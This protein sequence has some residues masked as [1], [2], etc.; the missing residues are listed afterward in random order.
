MTAVD[1]TQAIF[2]GPFTPITTTFTGN[3]FSHA[4]ISGSNLTAL[5]TNQVGQTVLADEKWGAGLVMFGGM[6]T[7][8]FHS[9]Q[10]QAN[11]LLDNIIDYTALAA[12]GGPNNYSVLAN[13]G[14]TLTIN[15]QTPLGPINQ[16]DPRI[17][18]YD[19]TG[20]LVAQDDNSAA[21]GRNSS[22]V[23]TA[24]MSGPYTVRVIADDT[25]G[26]YVL[27]VTGYTGQEAPFTATAVT[28]SDDALLGVYPSTYTIHLS[29]PVLL[30]TVAASDLTIDGVA[31]AGVTVVDPQTLTFDLTGTN[32]GNALYHAAIGAGVLTSWSGQPLQAFAATFDADLTPPQVVSSSLAEGDEVHT[33]SLVYTVTF[34]KQMATTGLGVAAAPLTNDVTNQTILP[35]SLTFDPTNTVATITYSNLAES[36]YTLTL[37][38]SATAFRDRRGLLLTGGNYLVDFAVDDLTAPFPTPLQPVAPVG[39]EVF[40]GAATGRFHAAGNVDSYTLNLDPGQALTI[41]LAGSDPSLSGQIEVL[42]PDG[43]IVGTASAAAGQTVFLQSAQVATAGTYTIQVSSLA[44]SGGYTVAATLNASVEAE[45]FGGPSDDTPATAQLIDG[46]AISLQGGADRLAVVGSLASATDTDEYAFTLASGQSASVVLRSQTTGVT[47]QL[48]LLDANGNVLAL[49]TTDAL[50]NQ[51]IDDFVGA[52][53]SYLIRITGAAAANYTVVVTRGADYALEPS[54]APAGPQLISLNNQVLGALSS[55]GGDTNQYLVQGGAGQALVLT[56]TTPGSGPGEPVNQVQPHLDL[57]DPSGHLVASNTG[58]AADGYN[59]LLSYTIPVGDA[60]VYKVV[61]TDVSTA[62]GPADTAQNFDGGGTPYTLANNGGTASSILSGGPTGNFLRLTPAQYY[63][64]N[65]IAF[66]RTHVG[67]APTTVVDFDFRMTPSSGQADGLG[68]AWLNTA[69]YGTTGSANVPGFGE[70]PSLPGSLGVGFDIYNNGSIDGNSNNEVSLHFNNQILGNFFPAFDLANGQFDHAEIRITAG[71]GG[72]YV[73]VT[74]TPNGGPAATLIDNYFVAGM[75]PYEGRAAFS[76][77]TG[78]QTADEDLDNITVRDTAGGAYTLN[79]AGALP[80]NTPAPSV[81]ATT[82]YDGQPT[83][84]PP[85]TLTVTLSSAIR[86]DLL[87]PADLT[88]G[89]GVTVTGVTM[90][91]GHTV[92]FG[93]SVPNV[94]ATYAY[95]FAAGAFTDLQGQPSAAY[96]SSFVI[97]QTGPVVVAQTPALQASVPFNQLGITFNENIDPTT[98]TTAD[99]TNFIGP[100]GVVLTSQVTSVTG[101]GRNFVIHFTGQTAPGTYTL[102]VGPNITDIAGNPMTA[103]FT[104]AINLQSPDLTVTNVSGPSSANFGDT[105]NVSWTV[106]NLGSDP[107]RAVERRRVLVEQHDAEQQ[108]R[109]AGHLQ[110]CHLQPAGGQRQLHA[111]RAGY[112]AVQHQR[113]AGQLLPHRPDRHQQPATG[114][115]REQQ[116]RRQHRAAVVA[117]PHRGLQRKLGHAAGSA[118][119]LRQPLC[120]QLHRQEHRQRRGARQHHRLHLPVHPGDAQQQR[121]AGGDLQRRR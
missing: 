30:S 48:A 61:V 106:K 81:V 78:G 2:Q 58:G 54:I 14:D 114:D 98:F 29:Q 87:S 43:S 13:A 85:T 18:L 10:P 97:D 7:T 95:S 76:A 94:E 24:L 57:Y 39:S 32:H 20:A 34:S 1:P 86:A 35:D 23:Y 65:T 90:T 11:N 100:G 53:Q 3:S 110:R 69:D 89:S 105:I 55:E 77:R 9:P 120:A 15:T 109:V 38:T 82:P 99:V 47:P 104:A 116:H 102:L 42:A 44:G 79:I 27:T 41:R 5:L 118:G 60:G 107:A 83:R 59:A 37:L 52:G 121:G 26:E 115:Q 101:S 103:A 16:L 119:D 92:V 46:S 64:L 6:T 19:P 88:I 70:E 51:R 22:L 21:D 17:E 84:T 8:N 68:F 56:T 31:A 93:L 49:G 96:S 72:S 80:T 45:S 62:V 108:Q 91:D 117:A 36:D 113:R 12:G 40:T 67:P 50:G 71:V 66:D 25:P 63:S 74:L 111:D 112:A 33:S 75:A 4:W 28:P 73:T